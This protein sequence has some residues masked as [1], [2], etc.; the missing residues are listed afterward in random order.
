M[1]SSGAESTIAEFEEWSV[2]NTW[3]L[4]NK[5]D[6]MNRCAMLLFPFVSL[7]L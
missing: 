1:E 2:E 5:F 7:L 6:E 3:I 4:E